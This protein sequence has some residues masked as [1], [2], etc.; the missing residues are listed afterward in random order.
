MPDLPPDLPRLRT[1]ETFLTFAL[2]HVQDAIATA[3]QREAELRA[4]RPRRVPPAFVLSYLREGGRPVPDSI[5]AGDCRMTSRNTKPVG[6][7]EARRLLADGHVS[8]CAVCR[9]DSEL[10]VLE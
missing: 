10:G 2:A 3:E 9:A 4:R 7:T 5:H 1:I 6:A 8:A